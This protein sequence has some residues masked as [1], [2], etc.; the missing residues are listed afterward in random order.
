M[1]AGWKVYNYV[2]FFS[3]NIS[4]F[5]CSETLQTHRYYRTSQKQST[6]PVTF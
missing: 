4:N 1:G 2:S 3:Q 5:M 6:L